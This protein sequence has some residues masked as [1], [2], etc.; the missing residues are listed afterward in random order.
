[1]GPRN[2]C[3]RCDT[4][5]ASRSDMCATYLRRPDPIY[6][7]A[8]LQRGQRQKPTRRQIPHP[9]LRPLL[10]LHARSLERLPRIQKHLGGTLRYDEDPRHVP[11]TRLKH[12]CSQ[13]DPTDT[14]KLE[15]SKTTSA[16]RP[17]SNHRCNKRTHL[18]P[19][20]RRLRR[21][22]KPKTSTIHM[23]RRNQKKDARA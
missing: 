22:R 19:R 10:A 4:I 21:A 7:L 14:T 9:R 8:K 13:S 12:R 3:R 2:R 20:T 1:M 16:Q 6:Q 15:R 11:R 5:P 18:Q 23:A 17:H